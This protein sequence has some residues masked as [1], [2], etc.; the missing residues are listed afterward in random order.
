MIGTVV[1]STLSALALMLALPAC[2]QQQAPA[3]PDADPALWVVKDAD[4]TVYLFG[5]VHVLKPGLTWFDEAVRAAF[6]RSDALV[7]E[8]VEPEPA[9]MQALV[10]ARGVNP[11]GPALTELVPPAK[12]AAF[13]EAM[14]ATGLPQAA[15]DR[16]DPWLAAVTLSLGPLQKLG[17]D[18]ANGPERVLADAARTAGKRVEGLETAEQQIGYFDALSQ[19]A[20]VAFLTSTIDDLPKV[21]E[22]MARMV[23]DWARGDPATLAA[24]LNDNLKDSPEVRQVLLTQRN[25][26]WAGWIAERMKTPGT[27]FVAVGA[28]H[29]AGA[30]AVQAELA[31]QGIKAERVAY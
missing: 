24:L 10:T 25:A 30:D 18:P 3:A 13:A 26:R 27:V 7:L 22:E 9:A 12:R 31:K 1:K 11:S 2:A 19:P 21:G 15:Y 6:D 28:G 14:R 17:Y 23:D 5:T 29:L 4:T 20:Q 16:F 8:M